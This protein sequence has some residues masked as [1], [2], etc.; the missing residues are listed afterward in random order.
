M[1]GFTI[2]SLMSAILEGRLNAHRLI[3][4]RLY[5]SD[6]QNAYKMFKNAGQY[7]AMKIMLINDLD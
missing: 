3:S 6:V 1:H 5:L 2:P 7:E 4:H